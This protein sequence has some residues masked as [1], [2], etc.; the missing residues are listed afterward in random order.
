MYRDEYPLAACLTDPDEQ[1]WQR[2]LEYQEWV[3]SVL[4]GSTPL[5]KIQRLSSM[6][7]WRLL[8]QM[9]PSGSLKPSVW[10]DYCPLAAL[11]SDP[12]RQ[13]EPDFAA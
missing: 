3:P 6:L 1:V 10:T 5:P 13:D 9:R 2:Y 8:H 12:R 11:E 7:L 4:D